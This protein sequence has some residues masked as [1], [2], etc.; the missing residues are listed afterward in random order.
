MNPIEKRIY[1]ALR[2]SPRLKRFVRNSYQRAF[3][4]LPRKRLRTILPVTTRPGYFFGFHD[5]TPA[6][7]QGSCHLTWVG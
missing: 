5:H 3:D 1:D 2:G 4:L 7:C 6:L